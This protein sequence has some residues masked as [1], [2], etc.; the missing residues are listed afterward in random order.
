MMP[1]QTYDVEPRAPHAGCPFNAPLVAQKFDDL[2]TKVDGINDR[3]DKVN[4]KIADHEKRL[5]T[6]ETRIAA[7]LAVAA[8]LAATVM[9]VLD[10]VWK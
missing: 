8:P 5:I 2:G 1:S 9:W 3:L 6:L 7:Y 10:R 4:G